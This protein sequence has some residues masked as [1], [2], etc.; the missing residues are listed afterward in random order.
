MHKDKILND[1]LVECQMTAEDIIDYV[2]SYICLN[3][4]DAI[5]VYIS[6]FDGL[7]NRNSDIDVYVL[8][9]EEKQQKT[10][11]ARISKAVCDIEFWTFESMER[12]VASARTM[13]DPVTLKLLQRI[14]RGVCIYGDS[15]CY[16]MLI[17]NLSGI[18]FNKLICEYFVS[19]AGGE[20][21][22]AVKMVKNRNYMAAL[23]CAR[24]GID[25]LI[26]AFNAK[27]GFANLNLKWSS[28]ILINHDG[29]GNAEIMS[30]YVKYQ[31]YSHITEASISREVE[32][33]LDYISDGLTKVALD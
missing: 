25:N 5:I 6:L 31:I 10:L 2:R 15:E 32:E 14:E 30:G 19:I 1:R 11:M 23:S 12:A 20:Y 7:G 24:R 21:D 4:E 9:S 29:F 13:K 22:D 16:K 3:S 17:K 26:A 33:M 8:S 18:D 27:N 28:T